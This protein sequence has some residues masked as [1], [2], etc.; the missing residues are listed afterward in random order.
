MV[1]DFYNSACVWKG[2]SLIDQN[3]IILLCSGLT[4]PS[5]NKKTGWMIQTYIL[6]EDIPPHKAV[7]EGEDISICG[8]CKLRENRWKKKGELNGCYV[9]VAR[10][11]LSI[12]KS[13]KKG[14]IPYIKPENLPNRYNRPIRKG[15]YGEPAIVP[16]SIWEKLQKTTSKV[17][18]SYTHM[19]N[20]P[21]FDKQFL[22][23][24]MAS[25]DSSEEKIIA[26]KMGARTYRIIDDMKEMHDDEILCPNT[27][28][29][30]QCFECNLCSGNLT[31]AKNIVIR[32]I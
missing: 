21:N 18:S 22:K 29:Q 15:S 8:N 31:K 4:I 26:N 19:W 25:V 5:T 23:T 20:E 30:R 12:W 6:R 7:W 10:A 16:Y 2:A 28:Q 14:N 13:Y 11:P 1:K 32:R 9:N 3:P 27:T 17:G 24:G